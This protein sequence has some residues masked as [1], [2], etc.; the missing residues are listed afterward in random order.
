MDLCSELPWKTGH[1]TNKIFMCI[2]IILCLEFLQE[3]YCL[4]QLVCVY[5][6]IIGMILCLITQ[7]LWNA[8]CGATSTVSGDPSFSDYCDWQ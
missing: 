7:Y 2:I 4:F 8:R 1:R 6:L 5:V 3:Q